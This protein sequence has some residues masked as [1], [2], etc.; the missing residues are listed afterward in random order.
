MKYKVEEEIGRGASAKV[1]RCQ[2]LDGLNGQPS[3]GSFAGSMVA[4]KWVQT[5]PR[6]FPTFFRELAT[7][8]H[9][10]RHTNIVQMGHCWSSK[11]TG[12]LVLELELVVG[13]DLQQFISSIGRLSEATAVRFGADIASGMGHIWSRGFAHR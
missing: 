2:V 3:S 11:D 4:L 7:L 8:Q 9:L 5:D 13:G 10:G 1:Y 12:T 6:R